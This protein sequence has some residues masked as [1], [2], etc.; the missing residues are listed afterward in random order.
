MRN[1]IALLSVLCGSLC[2]GLSRADDWPQ[3]RGPSAIGLT[4]EQG[5]PT[6]W[7]A[8]AD[9]QDENIAWKAN[10]PG[11]AWSQPIVVGDSIFVT[12]AVSE[13]QPK[14][15]AGR[16]GGGGRGRGGFGPGGRPGGNRPP[17]AEG[18]EDAPRG[19]APRPRGGFGR[20]GGAPPDAVYQW[21]VL[22]LDRATGEIRWQKTAH[23]GKPTIPIHRTNTYASET[24]VTDGER[25][26]AYFGMTGLYCY[27]LSGNQ[28]WSKEFE[29]FPM[30]MGWGAGSSPALDGDRVFVQCDN[31]EDSFLAAFNKLTGEEV[32]RDTRDEK[33]N[34]STP[35]LWKNKVRTELVTAGGTRV[36]SYDPASGKLLWELGGIRGRCSATPVGNDEMLYFGTGGGQGPGP[37]MAVKAGAAGEISANDTGEESSIAWT[38]PRGGPSMASPLLYENCLYVIDQRGGIVGCYD[39][40]TGEQYYRERLPDAKGFTSSPWAYDGKVFCLD[41]EGQTFVLKA[42]PSFE[43]LSTNK[44][45]DM[46]WSSV[47]I[48]DG[49]LLL[50]GVDRLY[51]IRKQ[52]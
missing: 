32:W 4:N 50:R 1:S 35:Y 7:N 25:V 2:C 15:Q 36:R 13:G 48:A 51:C 21:Q 20:G 10:L 3:F 43:V 46:F 14:P 6:E 28:V 30:A 5:L 23:E 49:K 33:S 29:S 47:A 38:L 12:T 41:E 11:V 18:G 17:N 42:G 9:G 31:E 44:L 45:D 22:C 24:P 27:D 26:Y 37:L 8:V 19:E 16:G 34:W 40:H 39:A 52:P